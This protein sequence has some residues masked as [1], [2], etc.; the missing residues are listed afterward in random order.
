MDGNL[1]PG[2]ETITIIKRDPTD[3]WLTLNIQTTI[4]N[5]VLLWFTHTFNTISIMTDNTSYMCFHQHQLTLTQLT[6]F[7]I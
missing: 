3:L 7:I 1:L 2:N 5:H 4:F 6:I